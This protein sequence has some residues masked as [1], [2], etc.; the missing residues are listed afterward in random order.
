MKAALLYGKEDLR[1]EEVPVP[2]ISDNEILLKVK[3]ALL[4][5][6]DIRM[7]KN[8]A[9]NADKE[10]PLILGHEFAGVIEKVGKNVK[11]YKPGM[12]VAVAPNM[13]CGVCDRCVSGNTQ[14]CVDYYAFGISIPGAFAEYVKLPEDTIRQGNIVEF[15]TAEFS[16][17]EF[18]AAEFSDVSFAE[19]ALA[20]PFSCVFNAYEHY[21]VFPGDVVLIVGAGPIGL[22]HAKLAKISGASAVIINDISRERL[23]LCVSVDPFFIPAGPDNLKDV[24]SKAS[25]GRG[26]DVA[27]T[28]APAPQAQTMVLELMNLEGR[29]SFFG[30]LPADKQIVGLNTNLIHYNQIAVSGTSRQN[31]RQYRKILEL[32]TRK[33]VGVK[34]LI[35]DTYCLRDLGT[36]LEKA[37]KGLGIKHAVEF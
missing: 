17:A 27:V 12:K 13:G 29:V 15:S 19:A 25:Y 32:I 21:R 1:V 8:G 31:L 9:K 36:A 14:Q 16:T 33:V 2:D 11:C 6:T 34:D 5:G 23:D 35:T 4:C 22:M 28:A 20:E 10:H 3:A 24:V 37:G 7:Y 26:L 30:G 18:S